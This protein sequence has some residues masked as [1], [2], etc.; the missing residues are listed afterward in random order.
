MVVYTVN[1]VLGLAVG[2]DFY[3]LVWEGGE[4]ISGGV[5]RL[6]FAGVSG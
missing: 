5:L 2:R 1:N 6:A 4:K 3:I